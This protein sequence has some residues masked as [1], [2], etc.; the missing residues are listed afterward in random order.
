MA[1]FTCRNTDEELSAKSL[2]LHP[3]YLAIEWQSGLRS[4]RATS[5]LLLQEL[6]SPTMYDSQSL[7][8]ETPKGF[9]TRL[10]FTIGI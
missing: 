2:R 9:Q 3:L 10:I 7:A 1:A 5:R 8:K 6:L 4:L